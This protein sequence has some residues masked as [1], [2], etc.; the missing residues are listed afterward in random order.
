M[1]A[2]S[3]VITFFAQRAGGAV[4]ALRNLPLWDRL[5][6]AAISYCRYVRIAFWPNPLIVLLLPR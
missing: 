3:S 1:A 6:N 4:A 2:I 5:C